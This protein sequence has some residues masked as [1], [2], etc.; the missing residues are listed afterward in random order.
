[1]YT[2]KPSNKLTSEQMQSNSEH[3]RK[4]ETFNP[5]KH[6]LYKTKIFK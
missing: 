2:H 6:T 3:Y 4:W 1:M 5:E